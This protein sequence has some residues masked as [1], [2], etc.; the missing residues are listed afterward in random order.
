MFLHARQDEN[1]DKKIYRFAL[2]GMPGSGKTCVLTAMG[3]VCRPT[4]DGSCCSPLPAHRLA[5]PEVQ[6]GWETLQKHAWRLSK[7]SELPKPDEIK[8]GNYPRYRYAYTDSKIGTTYFEIID[9]SAELPHHSRIRHEDCAE[10]LKRL[11]DHKVDGIIVLISVPE[12]EERSDIPDEIATI[13]K[14]FNFLQTNQTAERCYP[15]ALLLTKWDRQWMR[16][17][18][19]PTND[20]GVE[21][22]RLTQ[23][24]RQHSAYQS[25][26]DVLGKFASIDDGFKTFPV[27]ALGRCSDGRNPDKVPLESYGLP[28]VFGW[29][30]QAV[31]DSDFRRFE[32]LKSVLSWWRWQARPRIPFGLVKYIPAWGILAWKKWEQPVQDTWSLAES[33]LERLPQT[34]QEGKKRA[35]VEAA[36]RRLT[37][38]LWIQVLTIAVLFV[39]LPSKWIETSDSKTL[40]HA[41]TAINDSTLQEESLKNLELRLNRI[42][43]SSPYTV[44]LHGRDKGKKQSAQNLLELLY[45]KYEENALISFRSLVSVQD[46]ERIQKEGQQLLNDYPNSSARQEVIEKMAQSQNVIDD[47]ES[48]NLWTQINNLPI[49]GNDEIQALGSQYLDKFL[50]GKHRQKVIDL[51]NEAQRLHDESIARRDWDEFEETVR[52]TFEKGNVPSTLGMLAGSIGGGIRGAQLWFLSDDVLS[53]TDESIRHKVDNLET[54]FDSIKNEVS[55]SREAVRQLSNHGVSGADEVLQELETLSGEIAEK[56]DKFYYD[57]ARNIRTRAA[58]NYYLENAPR[59]TMK[60]YVANY[61]RYIDQMDNNLNLTVTASLSV[62]NRIFWG[63]GSRNEFRLFIN[64]TQKITIPD[65]NPLGFNENKRLDLMS[66]PFSIRGKL[67]DTVDIKVEML[68]SNWRILDQGSGTQAFTIEE[69]KHGVTLALTSKDDIAVMHTLRL[70]AT[71]FPSEPPLPEWKP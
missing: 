41:I 55:R 65:L 34:G 12:G 52:T 3:M 19:T 20:A 45:K 9:Y 32:K 47:A 13:Y 31:N 22:E 29:L 8:S 16:D 68:Y 2:F 53:K 62:G 10:L 33:L 35:S 69:L 38:I 1:L 15:V 64:G 26:H 44:P 56:E 70:R 39:A 67:T 58:I 21:A 7:D 23:F 6:E 57:N 60:V 36:K 27:S 43:H 40:T 46:N 66:H 17:V 25:V 51:M 14:L 18:A 5:P 63:A 28:F 48:A 37:L 42:V 4:T 30:I 54:Q 24:L 59:Q 11:T 49:E 50:T 61:L 71:G